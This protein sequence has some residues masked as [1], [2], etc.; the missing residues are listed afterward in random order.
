MTS[1]SP[2]LEILES[3]ERRFADLETQLADPATATNQARMRDLGREH[4]RMSEIVS[5]GEEYRRAIKEID[6]N[7]QIVRAGE[8]PE[9]VEMAREELTRLEDHKSR[10]EEK[11]RDLLTGPWGS[12][13]PAPRVNSSTIS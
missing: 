4:R 10:L 3:L 5:V 12:C 11:L 13:Y 8:E 7:E 6:G 9:L 1:A 2:M